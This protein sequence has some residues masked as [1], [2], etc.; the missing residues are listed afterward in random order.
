[1][2][3]LTEDIARLILAV[4]VM[5]NTIK[6][7]GEAVMAKQLPYTRGLGPLLRRPRMWLTLTPLLVFF[8]LFLVLWTK[9]VA[10]VLTGWCVIVG[11]Y[12]VRYWAIH[13]WKEFDVKDLGLY[14]PAAALL[15]VL[16]CVDSLREFGLSVPP[17]LEW[18]VSAGIVACA[19]T[20]C[21]IKKVSM[22]GWNW[23][24]APNM[25]L[26]LAERMHMGPGYRRR[27]IRWFLSRPKHLIFVGVT[28]LA[29][30]LLGVMFCI[31]D[32]RMAYAIVVLGMMV[33]N[34][35][36]FGFFELEWG[37]VGLVVALGGMT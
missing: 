30:E 7:G 29:F 18:D 19:W 10:P 9:G 2:A 16:C 32:L 3:A 8:A 33:F 26:L 11:V 27:M 37:M 23:A 21:G 15:M 13:S 12:L 34:Y 5:I 31:P 35:L 4:L 14:S 17:A 36:L 1:M 22:S 28:G 20:M 25:A 6:I 24:Y